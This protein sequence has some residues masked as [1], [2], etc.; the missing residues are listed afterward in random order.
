MNQHS[1]EPE[2]NDR[3]P[4]G[5]PSRRRSVIASKTVLRQFTY[6][7]AIQSARALLVLIGPACERAE[8][9]GSLRR[10]RPV[11]HDIDVVCIPKYNEVQVD[12][13][14]GTEK[15][16]QVDMVL[17]DL[18]TGGDKIKKGTIDGIPFDLYIASPETWATLLLIR[19]GSKQHNLLLAT[20]AQRL[21]YTLRADG[22]GVVDLVTER[23][24]AWE[25][26]KDIFTALR[27]EY[28]PPEKR[29][30]P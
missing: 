6:D 24:I 3:G 21:G 23:R 8:I 22:T 15:I 19:T 2:D 1:I 16:S 28:L 7:K 29:E 9:A 20:R 18:V 14:G 17:K 13:F 11:V 5:G 4:S 27:L 26:E 12:L 25:S 30:V 10:H